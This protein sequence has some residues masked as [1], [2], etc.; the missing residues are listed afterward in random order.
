MPPLRALLGAT[1]ALLK[2][3][4][5]GRNIAPPGDDP[6]RRLVFEDFWNAT[7]IARVLIADPAQWEA[8]FVGSFS[9]VLSVN[10]R[11]ALP[12]RKVRVVW[13]TGDA[14]LERLATVDW[15]HR[16]AATGEVL[17]YRA[18]LAALIGEVCD[19]SDSIAVGDS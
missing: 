11:L 19:E 5:R 4:Q 14:T 9:G 13:V 18:P 17:T 1:D 8:S 6:R 10:E 16:L 2:D 12:G 15:T 7:E 3:G